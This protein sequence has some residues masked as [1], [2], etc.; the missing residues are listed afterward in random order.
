[1]LNFKDV[2]ALLDS[3][4]KIVII[5]H[6]NPDA[7][8]LG[9]SLGLREYLL[10]K[11][12]EVTII[13]PSEYPKFLN[14]MNGEKSV[15]VMSEDNREQCFSLVKAA[16]IIFCLDFNSLS[17]IDVLG[18]EVGKS[19]ARKFLIDHH[20]DPE[21]FA[22]F[23]YSSIEAAATAELIYEFIVKLGDR[24]LIDPP[25]AESLYAGI[26]TD[27]GQFK[28]KNT[29]QNVHYV[30]ANLMELGADTSK[31]GS[32]IYD[33]N[34]YTRL[35]FLGFALSQRFSFLEEYNTA[36]IAISAEDLKQFDSKTGDTE[37]L[38]NYALSL[39]NAVLGALITEKSDGINLSLRSK[40][41]FSVN[42]FARNHFSG[43]G[44]KNAAGGTSDLSF[45]ETI[46]KFENIL[47]EYKDTLN[48]E[49]HELK[50]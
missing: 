12:H 25:M 14:W 24:E 11:N 10:K 18:E 15:I 23:S 29:T 31:V 3:P 50:I 5:P 4:Q 2:K 7:D 33:T 13:S 45:E 44:H 41:N 36:Y 1:M 37:G 17:R 8:A 43:G 9:S 26:M 28:H 32:L 47:K 48:K 30:S 22:D 6:H 27:T 35:K 34:S 19:K 46:K 20:L 40:G 21:D 39:D 49:A 16:T 42:D 38:V